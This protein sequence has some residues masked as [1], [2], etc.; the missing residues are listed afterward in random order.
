MCVYRD[1]IRPLLF[2]L[3]PEQSHHL[4]HKFIAHYRPILSALSSN[5]IYA[6]KDL[7][8]SL[9]GK[10]LSNPIGLA[11]GFD[12][13]GD[14]VHALKYLGFGYAEIGS[15]SA[16]P[17]VGNP[18]PRLW[19]LPAD[20]ALINWLGLNSEGAISVSQKLA[21]SQFSLPVALN[22]VKSNRPDIKGDLAWQDLLFTFRT[23]RHLPAL[24]VAINV[25]CPNTAEGILQE[26][27]M[28][29]SLLEHIHQENPAKLP[30]LIKLSED[31]DQALTQQM[32]EIGKKYEIA[33]YICGNTTRQRPK[34]KTPGH[35]VD[36]IEN[37]GLSGPPIK[38]LI[39]PLCRKVYELKETTQIIIGNGGISNGQDAYDY[40]RAGSTAVQLYT[41]LVYEGPGVVHKINQE[42]SSLLKRDK[43]TLVQA[44]GI[45][46]SALPASKL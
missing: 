23:I 37:G 43:L 34:L 30:I 22:I 19:R 36:S 10:T 14:L 38:Q 13:N 44:L 8:V 2:K 45:D 11:A 41:A 35:I 39:L 17:H 42:L 25:S 46:C 40:I 21:N 33:G 29:S 26:T 32:V 28:L 15:I 18:R 27:Q 16:Q 12:K 7:Q 1:F 9:F 31:G 24:Y 3:D 5:F 6:G 20:D 4:A